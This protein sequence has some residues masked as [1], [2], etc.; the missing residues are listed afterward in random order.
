MQHGQGYTR[1]L[2][3][4]P[5]GGYL[6]CIALATARA[7]ANKSWIKNV[8]T[9]LAVLMAVVVRWYDT[10]RIAQWRRFM[11]FPKAVNYP[12]IQVL[13]SRYLLGTYK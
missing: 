11:G 1:C 12:R 7:A 9:L 3:K 6:L 5:A 8:P 13:T 4:P 10:V 2:W